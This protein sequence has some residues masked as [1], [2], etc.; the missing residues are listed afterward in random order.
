MQ[1]S[2][3]STNDD[4]RDRMM[5]V[6]KWS[7]DKIAAYGGKFYATG[8]RKIALNFALAQDSEIDPEKLVQ[9]FDPEIFLIKLTPVNPTYS[10]QANRVESFVFS[11]DNCRNLVRSL[12]ETGYEVIVSI[13][14]L[15]ENDLGSNCGQYVMRHLQADDKTGHAYRE[16]LPSA[17]TVDIITRS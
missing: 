7:F 8:D 1:F 16:V 12:T 10:S 17:K 9:Y 14:E 3:H 15:K 11:D 6:R 2:I 4:Q 5:P 13:G